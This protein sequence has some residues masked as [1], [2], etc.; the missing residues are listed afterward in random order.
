MPTLANSARCQLRILQNVERSPLCERVTA[1]KMK[2][3]LEKA[4]PIL[5][6]RQ[7]A[8]FL[9]NWEMTRNRLLQNDR[10]DKTRLPDP[11]KPLPSTHHHGS[12]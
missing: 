3:C 6:I 10:H 2:T 8:A 4:K 7:E 9:T 12:R 5:A 1:H 11:R